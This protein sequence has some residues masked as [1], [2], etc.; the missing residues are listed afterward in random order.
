M[1]ADVKKSGLFAYLSKLKIVREIALG[2]IV[3]DA[4]R[5]ACGLFARLRI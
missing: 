2:L 4:G 1:S 5:K 3:A